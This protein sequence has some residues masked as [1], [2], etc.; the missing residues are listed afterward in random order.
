MEFVLLV[1]LLGI[2]V[3]HLKYHAKIKRERDDIAREREAAEKFNVKDS[4]NQLRFV[5]DAAFN[6]KKIMNKGEYHTFRIVES[7][8]K[9]ENKGYRVF[10]QT[11]LGEIISTHDR[12]AFQS[13]NSK[14]IDILIIDSF[15]NPAVAIEYQGSGHYQSNAAAR[16]AVKREA[17]RKA[18]VAYIEIFD[19]EDDGRLRDKVLDAL[20]STAMMA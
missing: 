15:G 16:D 6:K 3:Y 13:I 12:H 9:S 5:M 14:R 17:L 1:V 18:G 2:A 10:A 8:V 4:A 7:L 20:D 19:G 11:S